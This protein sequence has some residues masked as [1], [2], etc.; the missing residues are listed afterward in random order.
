[1]SI[2][3]SRIFR[4][5]LLD[6]CQY[7]FQR[8]DTEEDKAKQLVIKIEEETDEGKKEQ[9]KMDLED[10]KFKLRRRA[11]GNVRFIGELFK[12]EMLSPKIM[13]S[14]IRLLLSKLYM[15]KSF[16]NL[17]WRRRSDD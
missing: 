11:L 9:L 14:C 5:Q 3:T 2:E 10:T 7:E 1:M 6:K 4:K 16:V 17:K 15:Y 8:I 12:L 13:V